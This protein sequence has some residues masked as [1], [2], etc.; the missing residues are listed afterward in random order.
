MLVMARPT[1]KGPGEPEPFTQ[2]V[3]RFGQMLWRSYMSCLSSVYVYDLWF[4]NGAANTLCA[5]KGD[6]GHGDN[7]AGIINIASRQH[8]FTNH[9]RGTG[10]CVKH[11]AL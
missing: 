11:A 3:F 4:L 5:G 1:K 8:G 6:T 2:I 10:A 7:K 9:H